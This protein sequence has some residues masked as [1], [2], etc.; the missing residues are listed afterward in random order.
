MDRKQHGRN[1][2]RSF[3]ANCC[4]NA[5]KHHSVFYLGLLIKNSLYRYFTIVITF[6]LTKLHFKL[7]QINRELGP[8]IFNKS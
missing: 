1:K 2:K 6:F 4:K 5:V 7:S 8:S 3:L